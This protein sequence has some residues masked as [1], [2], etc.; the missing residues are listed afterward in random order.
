MKS[1]STYSILIFS[2]FLLLFNIQLKGQT[3]FTNVNQ[4]LLNPL[5]HSGCPVAIIDW[6]EDGLDDIVQLEQGHLAYVQIQR[7]NQQFETRYLGDFGGG[8]G[9]AWAM[10]VA[11]VD[12][13]GYKDIIAGGSSTAV[14]KILMID[15]TGT[16]GTLVTL[17]NSLFFMQ[18]V[19]FADFNNDGWIDLFCC[20][21]NAENHIY[22]N[23]QAGNLL[24][25]TIINFDVS[26]TDDSGNYGSTFTDFDNDG[27][28][29][30]YIAKCRQ[31]VSDTTDFR[32]INVL[33]VNN[34]N[35]TY[36]EA[37]ANYNLDDHWQSWTAS[38]G[39]IDNDGD[40]DLLVTNHDFRSQ[41]LINDGT[42][43]FT[44]VHPS[45]SGFDI[46][47]ITP[48]ES[49]M[50]DFDN[51]GWID[52]LATG[53]DSRLFHNNGNG[54]FTR[55]DNLFDNNFMESFATGD[56]NHDGFIDI[57]SSYAPYQNYTIPSLTTEDVI[58]LNKGNSN[59]FITLDLR[60]T[61]SN[62][63]AIGAK[64]LIYGS[65]GIQVRE[66][67]SGE[68]YGTTNSAMLHFG[69]GS[70][71][72]IDSLII[73]WPSGTIQTILNPDIDQ[74][75]TIKEND[76]VS[77]FVAVT[78]SGSMILCPSQ[79]IDLIATPGLN[80]LW[81]DGSSSQTLTVTQTGEYLVMGNTAGNNCTGISSAV[82]VLSPPD[83][84]PIIIALSDTEFCAGGSV[85]LEGPANEISYHWSNTDTTQTT[86]ITQSG[87][88]SLTIEGICST[89][90][91]A[92]ISVLV[93]T[94]AV[95]QSNDV[96]L[97][98][99]GSTTLT[100]NGSNVS[101]YDT[102]PG[103]TSLASGNNFTTPVLNDTTTYYFRDQITF[104]GVKDSL[105][106]PS[107]YG[108]SPYS[109]NIVNSQMY[110]D[111]FAKSTL[112]TVKVYTDIAG[113]RRFDLYNSNNILLDSVTVNVIK[114]V[115]D[116]QIINL[117]FNLVPGTGYYLE[118][119]AQVNTNL[120]GLGGTIGP[121]LKRNNVGVSYPYTVNNVISIVNSSAGPAFYYYFY[122]WHVITSSLTCE[123]EFDSVT[124]FVNLSSGLNE[125]N[126]SGINVYPN[127][128]HDKINIQLV[129][130]TNAFVSLIDQ[131]GRI[132]LKDKL[133]KKENT[134]DISKFDS[135][136]YNLRIQNE[137][138]IIT[139]KIIIN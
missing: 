115:P 120:P 13:N 59:H 45:I 37:A 71:T 17:A 11:D 36:T 82:R 4:R 55:V 83:Q 106:M 125:M 53:S 67:R 109:G 2:F 119:N 31:I 108:L 42:G 64:A 96:I 138:E 103:G 104:G 123:S 118:T 57:Y 78:P 99:A 22:L 43:H 9:Y 80:Y 122:D 46:S 26:A 117:N 44:D 27:D 79:T 5:F 139:K 58:W 121:R 19:T 134:F 68:S 126:N 28:F 114:L 61:T 127:P 41:L 116:S 32:R 73:R 124:V 76:C 18:N 30:L 93:R 66:V 72:V 60:G 136:I 21:D 95:P 77:P 10:G 62:H 98:A 132:I 69:L 29:D 86:S 25:S 97:T 49:M 52:I 90:T 74:F 38:F 33:F 8:S 91:S 70:S 113:P 20:D 101:W 111:V 14:K 87:S 54:T 133:I 39:D 81:S 75:M 51:D 137:N 94:V 110:F 15:N 24:P 65:W 102:F 3:G 48:L 135:G 34:G 1:K 56:I 47:D 105:G 40:Q 89:F 92:P 131:T 85:L 50:E 23:D 16:S 100:A 12:H 7:P 6:N 35:G 63:G 128:S 112:Q 84:T 130:S 107:A 129:K 88:Y